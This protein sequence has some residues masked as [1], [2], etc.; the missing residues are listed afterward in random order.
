MTNVLFLKAT[1]Y[2]TKARR[3]QQPVLL[4]I[5]MMQ[6]YALV[7]ILFLWVL[8]PGAQAWADRAEMSG[9]KVR[10]ILWPI[11][12][13]ATNLNLFFSFS[14]LV[15][16]ICLVT[17]P[18]YFL[19]ALFAFVLGSFFFLR[20]PAINGSDYIQTAFSI[21]CIG[22]SSV[23]VGSSDRFRW[24]ENGVFNLMVWVLRFQLALI[25][26]INGWDKLW[27]PMWRSG[28]A[29]TYI[30][31]SDTMMNPSAQWLFL[32]ATGNLIWAWVTIVFEIGF[33]ALIWFRR[34][35]TMFLCV[36]II[37]HILIWWALTLPDFSLVMIICYVI[38]LDETDTKNAR[39]R[40]RRWLP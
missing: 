11:N 22:L 30:A 27:D 34:T 4:F 37:F 33:F 20:L 8:V 28:E 13:A 38:F 6:G 23:Y 21:W 16:L 24:V 17:R 1:E 2:L 19:N 9:Y 5:K 3:D 39:Q 14:V 29:I 35:R 10:L 36:G 32:N 40:F 7:K 31:Y 26:L 18:D 25:Y 12:L 15:I